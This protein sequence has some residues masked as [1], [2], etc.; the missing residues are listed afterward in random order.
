M[1]KQRYSAI[2][3]LAQRVASTS[4]GA[5]ILS[6]VMHPLDRLTLSLSDGRI[7]AAEVLAGLP[8]V[9]IEM[10]GARSHRR[11]IVPLIY[12][13]IESETER[14]ALIATN[15]GQRRHP[16]W[17]YNLMAYPDVWGTVKGRRQAYRAHEASVVEYQGYWPAAVRTYPGYESYR[18]RISS[19][20]IPILILDPIP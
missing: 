9:M 10:T 1:A 8:I 3:R 13:Q 2:H 15:W 6:R 18:K 20:D 17:Y 5:W 14:L 12:V 16:A 19:R 7:S 4:G 11:R